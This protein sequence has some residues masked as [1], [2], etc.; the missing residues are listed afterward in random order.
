MTIITIAI[1]NRI[2]L[3]Q[4]GDSTHSHDQEITPHNFSTI[5]TIASSPAKPIPPLPAVVVVL[6]PSII[7]LSG[8]SAQSFLGYLLIIFLHLCPTPMIICPT[9]PTMVKFTLIFKVGLIYIT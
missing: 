2:Q 5:N 1:K 3:I 4:I 9:R 6:L 8:C 7:F